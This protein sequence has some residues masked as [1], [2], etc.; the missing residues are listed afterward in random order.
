M[1]GDAPE[2]PDFARSPRGFLNQLHLPS[3]TIL[4]IR[5]LR[6]RTQ[7][8]ILRRAVPRAPYG[9]R[10]RADRSGPAEVGALQEPQILTCS[11]LPNTAT[12][13]AGFVV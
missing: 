10:H 11:L 6:L 5:K 4:L 3:R 2:A 9:R 7:T 8:A 1:G 13:D 12:V